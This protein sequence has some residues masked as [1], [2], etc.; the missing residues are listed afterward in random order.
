MN[1]D[2]PTHLILG[3]TGGIGHAV[4]IALS[5]RNVPIK[6]LVRNA[7]KAKKYTDG[8]HNL[9]II[10]GDASKPEDLKKAFQGIDVVHYCINVPYHHWEKHALQLLKNC[11]DA[12]IEHKVKLIFPGNVYVY[13]HAKYNPVDEKHPHA[14]HTKKGQIRMEMEEM[15]ALARKE[16]GLDY[17]IIRMPDFYGPYVVNGFSEK[18]YINALKGKSLQWIGDLDMDIEYIFIEDGGEAMVMAALSD[19]SNGEVFNIPGVEITAS[20]KYLS[21]IVNQA[22][23]R[24]KINTMNSDF[25]FKLIG[26]FSPVVKELVEML[27]LKREKLILKGNKF[28]EMIGPMPAT[29]Y[30]TGIS[31]TLDW[32]RDFYKL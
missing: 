6:V 8:L 28:E 7:E 22:G 17:T 26:W 23:T 14:A 13:G 24:S 18:I 25:V 15:L 5:K 27:Y 3:F 11:V 32:V 4:A 16:H 30:K 2:K 20:R 10:Q 31:K 29:D 1:P 9:E 19:K 12:A 21:E